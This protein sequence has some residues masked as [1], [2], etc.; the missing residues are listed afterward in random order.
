V[1][2]SWEAS[3]FFLGCVVAPARLLL[4]VESSYGEMELKGQW[5]FQ[6]HLFTLMKIHMEMVHGSLYFIGK[7]VVIF[8]M[9]KII[10][11]FI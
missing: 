1:A 5:K 6:Q 9:V 4:L 11:Y 8:D 7:I 3:Y 2:P 10:K